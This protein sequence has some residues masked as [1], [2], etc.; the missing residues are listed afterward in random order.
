MRSFLLTPPIV[1]LIVLTGMCLFAALL[2]KL[3]FK[4]QHKGAGIGKSYACG[5]DVKSHL[6]QPD[7]SQFFPFAFF[8]TILHVVTL[9]ITTALITSPQT[10]YI[11]VLYVLGA[12]ISLFIL[13]RK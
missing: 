4:N 12:V 2:S 9:I 6:M 11:A 8:F 10:F 5:E 7:Y 3:S 13:Y 1:F